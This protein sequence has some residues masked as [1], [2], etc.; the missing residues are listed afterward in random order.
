MF[1]SVFVIDKSPGRNDD[2]VGA[3]E[4]GG[5]NVKSSGTKEKVF[6]TDEVGG[7]NVKS[8]GK[9]ENTFGAKEVGEINVETSVGDEVGIDVGDRDG[10]SLGCTVGNEVV[11]IVDELGDIDGLVEGMSEGLIEGSSE[12]SIEGLDEGP[13]E[14]I[15]LEIFEGS[16][17]GKIEGSAEGISAKTA[18][19]L[20]KLPTAD[21]SLLL[22]PL[23]F[24]RVIFEPIMST[25][26]KTES[27][28]LAK[29]EFR[30]LKRGVVIDFLDSWRASAATDRSS[31]LLV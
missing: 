21:S 15:T 4:V 29:I 18:G 17:E 28:T 2:T 16:A 19:G 31:S 3:G 11:G 30:R 12:G 8:P 22:F 20:S 14:C 27:V 6:G 5:S 1:K 13:V 26:K 10:K 25:A 24:V 9:K 7:I 23:L